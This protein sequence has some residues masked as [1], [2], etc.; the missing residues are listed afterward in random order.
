MV[1]CGSVRQNNSVVRCSS[2]VGVVCKV[3]VV[4]CGR[5]ALGFGV[6]DRV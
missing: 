4:L 5:L 2:V 3:V 6:V 1:S